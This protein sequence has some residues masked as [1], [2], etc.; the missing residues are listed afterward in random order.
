MNSTDKSIALIDIALRRRFT[1]LKMQPNTNLVKNADAKNMMIELNDE[2]EKT[3]GKDHLIGYSYFMKIENNID[4]EFVTEYKIKPLLEE[5]Y[6]GDN[7]GLEKVL[8]IL[9][10]EL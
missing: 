7:D 10:F 8:N 4:L 9:D 2:I 6:Y 1:F 5:Y 3:L